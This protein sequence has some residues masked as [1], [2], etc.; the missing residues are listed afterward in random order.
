MVSQCPLMQSDR[1]RSN[2]EEL[3]LITVDRHHLHLVEVGTKIG[4]RSDGPQDGLALPIVE[5][6][7]SNLRRIKPIENQVIKEPDH[8]VGLLLVV[9]GHV[10]VSGLEML[11]AP[12]ERVITAHSRDRWS[13]AGVFDAGMILESLAINRIQKA[14]DFWNHAALFRERVK[15]HLVLDETLK[16][17]QV[18]IVRRVLESVNLGVW[19]K[20]LI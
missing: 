6:Q 9:H 16:Q 12:E 17:T 3:T 15:L 4:V 18:E 8:H 5:D 7:D 13:I 19:P 2:R 1:N 11:V 14:P 10:G 20:L